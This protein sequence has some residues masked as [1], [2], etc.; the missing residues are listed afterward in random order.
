MC[1]ARAADTTGHRANTRTTRGRWAVA[2]NRAEHAAYHRP[3]HDTTGRFLVHMLR[4]P[5]SL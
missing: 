2:D 3:T 5:L 4:D 1:R